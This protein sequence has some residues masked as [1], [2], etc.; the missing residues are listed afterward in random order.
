VGRET[1]TKLD[2]LKTPYGTLLLLTPTDCVKDRL[3]AYVHWADHQAFEQAL[4]V[5]LR[6]KISLAS[7]EAWAKQESGTKAFVEFK[8]ALKLRKMHPKKSG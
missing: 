8:G 2:R 7:I 6:H 1:I 5:A 3:A 4:L